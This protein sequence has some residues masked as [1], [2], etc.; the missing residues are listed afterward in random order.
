MMSMQFKIGNKTIG[1]GKPCLIVAEVAQAHDG[2]LG[3]AHAFIDAIADTGADAVKFQTHIAAA[4][5]TPDEPW[6]I[7]FSR[8]D[9]T[10]YDYWKRMEFTEEQWVGLKSHADKCGLIFLS[11][12]FSSEAVDLLLR[13]GVSAWKVPS[14]ETANIPMLDQMIATGQPIILSTGMSNLEEID[15]TVDRIKKSAVPLVVLQCT[16]AY[17]CPPE[18]IGVNMISFFQKRYGCAAGLSDHSGTIYPGLASATLGSQML[19][20]HVTLSREMF[21]PDVPAS[22]TTAELKQL[23]EGIRFIEKMMTHPVDKQVMTED[24]KNLRLMFTK[25]IVARKDLPAG[26]ILKAEHLTVKKPGTG[27]SAARM[28]E[29]IGRRLKQPL[30]ADA[31]LSEDELE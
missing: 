26:T 5:S 22:I 14:G 12:P 6:R 17:P 11:S 15:R 31:L 27:I 4:E 19:E 25:S 9:A 2:S 13:A 16:T 7:K 8:Q 18:K 23:V 28:Q 30:K 21:G 3:M 20:V 24:L 1:E 29:V 10:R